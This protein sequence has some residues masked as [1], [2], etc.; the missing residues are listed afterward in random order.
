MN[1]TSFKKKFETI[2]KAFRR[3]KKNKEADELEFFASTLPNTEP[4][5]E[6]KLV[7]GLSIA[8]CKRLNQ[9]KNAK[10]KHL[11]LD[12]KEL[13]SRVCENYDSANGL[14]E[15]TDHGDIDNFVV[16][17]TISD[18]D[19]QRIYRT[20]LFN[21]KYR[22]MG[23][24]SGDVGGSEDATVVIFAIDITEK[25]PE[26]EYGDDGELK[27]AFD[28]FDIYGT[29]RLNSAELKEAFIALGFNTKSFS[30]FKAI[31][32]IDNNNKTKSGITWET[33][34][35]TV[36]SL[37]GDINSKKGVRK[38][39]DLFVDDPVQ[40]VVEL[41]TM[42]RV[43][44]ELGDDISNDLLRDVLKRAAENGTFIGFDEFYNIMM[45]FN[46]LKAEDI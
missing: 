3:I 26:I 5:R 30:V 18:H 19:P 16:R 4:V 31:E 36:K 45:T 44:S 2:A 12:E 32:Q 42:R 37:I 40:D 28:L 43:A 34:R 11:A 9:F 17:L 10:D 27:E 33:F 25:Q 13:Y 23:I 1:Y 22:F 39:F 29:G 46:N 24:A 21:P 38:I 7:E 41:N 14:L 8:A 15:L 20:A 35:D 6:L